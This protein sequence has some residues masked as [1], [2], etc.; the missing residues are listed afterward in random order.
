MANALRVSNLNSLGL[1]AAKLQENQIVNDLSVLSAAI[2][3]PVQAGSLILGPVNNAVGNGNDAVNQLVLNYASTN[4]A[5]GNQPANGQYFT[6]PV[7]VI[8]NNVWTTKHLLCV[9][10]AIP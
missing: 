8:V 1:P 6:V 4:N 2:P 3:P 5:G 7:R 10:T 9:T